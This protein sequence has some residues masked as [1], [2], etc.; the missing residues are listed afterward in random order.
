MKS[1]FRMTAN[2]IFVVAFLVTLLCFAISCTQSPIAVFDA[3]K[4]VVAVGESIQFTNQS[5]CE[6]TRWSWDFGDGMICNERSPSHSY[7][8]KG[9]YTASLTV[10]NGAGSDFAAITI[11]VLERPVA[12][13]S[14]SGT[15]FW[16]GKTVEFKDD[17]TGDIDS[18]LW[19]FGDGT[20]STIPRPSHVYKNAG[21]YTVTLTVSNPASSNTKSREDYIIVAGLTIHPIVF[22][23]SM[24]EAGECTPR[25]SDRFQRGEQAWIYFE[26]I[27]FEHSLL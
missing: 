14:A 7:G 18:W 5:M 4:T 13:F 19:D 12:D 11:T 6:I 10:S 8:Q 2:S 20:T 23:S 17:S 16:I 27:G 9:N 21:T 24:T 22:C 26:V 25:L 3:S 15:E 1:I